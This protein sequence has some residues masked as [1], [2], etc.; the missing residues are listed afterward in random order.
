MIRSVAPIG[1]LYTF[2]YHL[3]RF[4]IV[5]EEFIQHKLQEWVTTFHRDV[6]KDGFGDL[7]GIDAVFLD[8]PSP[9]EAIPFT[10]S[11][12]KTNS[13]S[14]LATFSPCIEQVV[15]T[16]KVLQEEGFKNIQMFE[17]L[18]KNLNVFSLPEWKS[19]DKSL[20]KSIEKSLTRTLE[21]E[22]R[23]M[24]SQ[25]SQMVKGHTS[26]LVFATYLN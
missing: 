22:K 1:H 19:L 9:W 20:D 4:K 26:Y 21:E 23:I 14:R 12:F 11:C 17:V 10:K 8:L 3:E 25:C 5:Q 18:V 13:S 15:K 2:E 7:E 16:I 24:T 6:C